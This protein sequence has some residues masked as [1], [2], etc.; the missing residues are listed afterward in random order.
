MKVLSTNLS[1]KLNANYGDGQKSRHTPKIMAF[2]VT[3]TILQ[4]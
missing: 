4:P 3:V 1:L 2:T